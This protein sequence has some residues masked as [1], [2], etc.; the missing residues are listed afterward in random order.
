[1]MEQ[2]GGA[3]PVRLIAF[4]FFN[5]GF[6]GKILFFKLGVQGGPLEVKQPGGLG[7]VAAG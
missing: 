6:E 1:M 4:G 2:G 7:P 3:E 5:A